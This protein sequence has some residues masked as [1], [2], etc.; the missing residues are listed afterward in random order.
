MVKKCQVLETMLNDFVMVSKE[1]YTSRLIN[2]PLANKSKHIT[3][4]YALLYGNQ[5]F[6]AA[7]ATFIPAIVLEHIVLNFK[8]KRFRIEKNF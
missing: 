8:F 4:K 5:Q 6:I 3:S 2:L 7:S 1:G